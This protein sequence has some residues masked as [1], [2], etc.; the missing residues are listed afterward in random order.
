MAWTR[1]TA[2]EVGARGQSWV[3]FKDILTLQMESTG[4]VDE[5]EMRCERNRKVKDDPKC[6]GN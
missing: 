6:R 1:V 4:L 5:L 3:Y 2:V